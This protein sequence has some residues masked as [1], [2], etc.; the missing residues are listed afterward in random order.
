MT[1]D[2][3]SELW[4]LMRDPFIG[5]LADELIVEIESGRTALHELRSASGRPTLSF[6]LVAL[7]VFRRRGGRCHTFSGP[8]TAILYV[9]EL[10]LKLR[11]LD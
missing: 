7:V 9:T 3:R 2:Q 6:R 4:H 5:R 1:G 8:G 11:E 10:K